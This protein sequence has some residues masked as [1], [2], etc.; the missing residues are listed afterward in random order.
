[1]ASPLEVLYVPTAKQ[2]VA[3]V[4]DTAKSWLARAPVGVWLDTIDQ[5][6]AFRRSTKGRST[7]ALLKSP[8]P[9]QSVALVHDTPVNS[10][11]CAPAGSGLDPSTKLV[12]FQRS[13]SVWLTDEV[14]ENPTAKQLVALVHET[15]LSELND[16]PATFALATIAQL[17]PFQRSTNVRV[18]PEVL[19]YPTATQ[20][21][22]LVH[23]TPDSDLPAGFGL[24]TIVQLVLFQ[25]SINA[26]PDDVPTAKQFVALVHDT[27]KSSG[28][29]APDGFGLVTIV[30]LVPFHRSTNVRYT[31]ES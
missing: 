28:L 25:R 8:T 15:P 30:Q 4:H 10:L 6:P 1:V 18:P 5:P 14:T 20:F 31:F 27:P 17:V 9:T 11:D 21:V 2:P 7:F 29:D 13:I 24:D 3:L 12:P 26:P 16:A 23:D 19:K 22:A